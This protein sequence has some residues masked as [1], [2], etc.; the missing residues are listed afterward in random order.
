[1]YF[2]RTFKA[3]NFDFPIQGHSRT[4]KVRANPET[5]YCLNTNKYSLRKQGWDRDRAARR[6]KGMQQHPVL[7]KRP[8][9][10][11]QPSLISSTHK[12]QKSKM[13]IRHSQVRS[14]DL[15]SDLTIIKLRKQS[16]TKLIPL[17]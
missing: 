13:D 8:I 16:I 5:T 6:K 17:T 1:M 12:I 11:K 9:S 14:V 15:F 2:S 3:L 7:S 4:F 10:N